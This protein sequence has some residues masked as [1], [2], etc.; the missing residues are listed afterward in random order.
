MCPHVHKLGHQFG[1][2]RLAHMK[3]DRVSWDFSNCSLDVPPHSLLQ[4]SPT[5]HTHTH[6]QTFRFLYISLDRK[7]KIKKVL[8]SYQSSQ[9][10]G[11]VRTEC[12]L[13]TVQK[14]K[15]RHRLSFRSHEN[16][17]IRLLGTGH[18]LVGT[19]IYPVSVRDQCQ[20]LWHGEDVLMLTVGLCILSPAVMS[21]GMSHDWT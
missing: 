3:L 4:H 19:W 14:G 16:R 8:L 20:F 13:V 11:G 18:R 10:K 15:L 9:F 6:A 12:H 21:A 1:L 2:S 17:K 7:K 5:P